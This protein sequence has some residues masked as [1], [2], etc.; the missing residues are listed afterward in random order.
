MLNL[1]SA[2]LFAMQMFREDGACAALGSFAPI[3]GEIRLLHDILKAVYF[4]IE[5]GNPDRCGNRNFAV[6]DIERALQDRADL[7]SD[8]AAILAGTRIADNE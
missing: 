6:V 4:R 3:Q 8:Q 5:M 2:P 7:L 1:N